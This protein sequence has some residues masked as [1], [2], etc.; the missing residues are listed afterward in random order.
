[1]ANISMSFAELVDLTEKRVVA[2]L[3]EVVF[4]DKFP[5]ELVQIVLSY[6]NQDVEVV[7]KDGYIE[8]FL[9]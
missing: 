2:E 7:Y 8:V 6:S 3:K 4:V 1:M 9:N 5:E